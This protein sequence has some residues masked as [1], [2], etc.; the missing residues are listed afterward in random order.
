MNVDALRLQPI[1]VGVRETGAWAGRSDVPNVGA[2][3]D[4]QPR[5]EKLRSLVPR[6]DDAALDRSLN[7]GPF[8]RGQQPVLGRADHTR[9][10]AADRGDRVEPGLGPVVPDRRGADDRAPGQ[11]ELADARGIE[12]VNG[13]DRGAVERA[14]ELA[15][16]AR[17]NHGPRRKPE[18]V[19]HGP[20]LHRVGRKHF[21]EQRNRRLLGALGPRREHWALLRLTPGEIQHRAGQD[22]LGLRMSRD[23][24]PRNIDANDAHAIDLFGQEPQRHARGSRHAKIDDDDRVVLVGIGK[25][26]DRVA[27]ILEQ[28]AGDECL[29]IERHIAD[30]AFGAVEVRGEGQSVDAACRAAKDGRGSPHPKANAQRAEGRAHA[31]R[32]VVRADGIV[33]RVALQR[34]ARARG[35]RGFAQDLFARMAIGTRSR[36]GRRGSYS[37]GPRRLAIDGRAV[38]GGGAV[39]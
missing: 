13:R 9:R 20:D 28:L 21:S 19:E 17:R 38:E 14:V 34:F 7:E 36:P 27:D 2:A 1:A 10:D 5:N 24:E 29:R 37:C 35:F 30:R 18:K 12:R 39:G 32:L 6:D 26:E 25:L 4:H 31:L 16:F 3:L 23:A 22:I 11:F 33:A 15:P 8:D